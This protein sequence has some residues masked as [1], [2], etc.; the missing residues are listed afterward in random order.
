M[1]N[2]LFSLTLL[3]LAFSI[4]GLNAQTSGTDAPVDVHLR[5][6]GRNYGDKVVLRW[7]FNE[8]EAW[9]YLNTQGFILERF[10][11]DD[12]TN[13]ASKG[14]TFK[15]LKICFKAVGVTCCAA[16]LHA[17]SGSK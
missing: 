4:S 8:S 7:A 10:E 9:R 17:L 16:S 12:K 6:L 3:L 14:F 2:I 15:S 5:M 1:K 11:L 13:Q